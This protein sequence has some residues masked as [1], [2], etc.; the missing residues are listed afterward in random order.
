MK[1][2]FATVTADSGGHFSLNENVPA[3][4]SVGAATVKAKDLTVLDKAKVA[5]TVT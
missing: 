5:Y 4:A 2:V 3:G 1:T